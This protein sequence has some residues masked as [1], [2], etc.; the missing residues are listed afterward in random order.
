M[1]ETKL[2]IYGMEI[3]IKADLEAI[4]LQAIRDYIEDWIQ[5]I[6]EQTRG[7]ENINRLLIVLLAFL[8]ASIECYKNK[9]TLKDQERKIEGILKKLEGIE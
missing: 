8:N 3:P 6:E 9:E 5:K 2:R 7:K 4:E 1:I